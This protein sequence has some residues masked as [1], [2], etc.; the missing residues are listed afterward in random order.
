MIVLLFNDQFQV[1]IRNFDFISFFIVKRLC[2]VLKLRQLTVPYW[3]YFVV[4]TLSG[5]SFCK[6]HQKYP[7]YQA[8]VAL[9]FF[10]KNQ[11]SLM[12][13]TTLTIFDVKTWRITSILVI[14]LNCNVIASTI[15]S[16][17]IKIDPFQRCHDFFLAAPIRLGL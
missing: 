9:H 8:L 3:P 13:L 17:R 16:K 4:K 10:P 12:F 7:F 15:T 11:S 6:I 14:L 2:K 5:K 1:L